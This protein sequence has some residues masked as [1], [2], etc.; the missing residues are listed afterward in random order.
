[1]SSIPTIETDR[2]T[3]RPFTP[4]DA[5]EII[6]LAGERSIAD[7]SEV[8]HPYTLVDAL[9]WIDL[10][11]GAFVRNEELQ[12]AVVRRSDSLLVGS[13]SLQAVFTGHQAELGYWIGHPFW[14]NGYAT[15]ACRAVV[16]WGFD[17]FDL[18]RIHA[19]HLTRNPA[20]G[21][22]LEKVGM[23]LEGVSPKHFLKWGIPED[24]S[25]WGILRE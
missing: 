15:E 18:I 4:S 21:R 25:F 13:V 19:C 16:A 9:D 17:Q 11:R 10:H 24:I 20:S 8:P 6:R 5:P 3:L 1:M 2:L 22:V 14:G 7:T 23:R 12:L